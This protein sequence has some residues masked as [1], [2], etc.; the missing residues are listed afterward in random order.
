[1]LI[2]EVS[3]QGVRLIGVRKTE[4]YCAGPA[5]CAQREEILSRAVR[6]LEGCTAVLCTKIGFEPWRA[7]EAAGI[8]PNVEQVDLPIEQGV[9][10]VYRELLRTGDDQRLDPTA[11]MASA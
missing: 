9:E 4:R 11:A 6:A 10:A 5:N 2:Y 1:F 7:L 8:V 3:S